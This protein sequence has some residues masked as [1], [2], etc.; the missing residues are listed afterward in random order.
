MEE[1]EGFVKDSKVA[2]KGV[3]NGIF[4]SIVYEVI[5]M[6]IIS[7]FITSLVSSKNP[8]ATQEQLEVL[9]DLEYKSF[10][11]GLLIS[12]LSSFVTIIVFTVIIKFD[13]F[14]NLCKKAINSKTLKYGALCGGAMILFSIIYNNL[15]VSIFDLDSSGNANQE[16][17]VNL[18][19]KS[20]FLGFLSVVVLAPISEELTYR[21]C[22]FGEISKKKKW[23]AYALTG[24]VFMLM[25]SIAS[26]SEAGGFNKA[27]AQELIYLPPYLFSGLALCYVYDKS[28]NLGSSFVAHA[29]NNLVSFL[30]IVCL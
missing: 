4:G 21:Y 1:K 24:I 15:A 19:K 7:L 29:L 9:F 17:I 14:K 26:Y 2:V 18:I 8:N 13:T 20:A 3:L 23:I 12:C 25:H 27:F 16:A 5:I 30:A 6:F 22:M 11:Y 10:P 28:E